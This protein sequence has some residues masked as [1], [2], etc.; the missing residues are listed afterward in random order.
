MPLAPTLPALRHEV[1]CLPR[2]D[3]D[4]PRIEGFVHYMDDPDS[5]RS[6]ASHNVRRCVECGVASY[7]PIGA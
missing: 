2:P 5:G 4:E 7:Q 3:L 6:R 1:F